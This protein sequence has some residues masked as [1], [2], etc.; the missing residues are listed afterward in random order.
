MGPV[1]AGRMLGHTVS[2]TTRPAI[3]ADI[4]NAVMSERPPTCDRHLLGRC[5]TVAPN[6][7]YLLRPPENLRNDERTGANSKHTNDD[8]SPA[9]TKERK[10]RK[11]CNK[12][13]GCH[14]K[15]SEVI[16]RKS[17]TRSAKHRQKVTAPSKAAKDQD[18]AERPRRDARSVHGKRSGLTESAAMPR[19]GRRAATSA[20]NRHWLTRLVLGGLICSGRC[21]HTARAFCWS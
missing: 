6:D 4:K 12:G 9:Q 20:A 21:L 10:Y 19:Q 1:G 7:G 13:E 8:A 17:E 15:P 2:I 16:E 3:V 5:W 18:C 11:R 14:Q